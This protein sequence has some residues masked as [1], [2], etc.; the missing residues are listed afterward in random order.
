M[1]HGRLDWPSLVEQHS[2][3]LLADQ[4][5]SLPDGGDPFSV[6]TEVP[7]LDYLSLTPVPPWPRL[8]SGSGCCESW[9]YRI[10]HSVN[11]KNNAMPS[12]GKADDIAIPVAK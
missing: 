5:T 12:G 4:K 8:R 6:V 1:R 10:R 9:L 3:G 7:S 2:A 11:N